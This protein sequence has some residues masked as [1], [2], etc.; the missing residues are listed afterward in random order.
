MSP[1]LANIIVTL[2]LLA[3]VFFAVRSIWKNRKSGGCGCGCEGC[4]GSCAGC[5]LAM[6]DPKEKIRQ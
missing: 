5:S 6:R 3:I 4:S 2:I 1:V